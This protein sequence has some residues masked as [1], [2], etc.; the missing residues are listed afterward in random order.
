MNQDGGGQ[1]GSRT[2]ARPPGGDFGNFKLKY[3]IVSFSRRMSPNRSSH[4]SQKLARPYLVV[5]AFSRHTYN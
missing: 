3:V 5:P 1:G 2:S 4:I